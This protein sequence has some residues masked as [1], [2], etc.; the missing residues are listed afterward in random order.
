MILSRMGYAP[1]AFHPSIFHT[2]YIF[3]SIVALIGAYANCTLVR[4]AAYLE[5]NSPGTHVMSS[6]GLTQG[7]K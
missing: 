2:R 7:S 1:D 6:T 4:R 3:H 5:G